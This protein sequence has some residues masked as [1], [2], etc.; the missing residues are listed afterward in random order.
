LCSSTAPTPPALVAHPGR[1][2][3]HRAIGRARRRCRG[4]VAGASSLSVCEEILAKCVCA[5]GNLMS[6]STSTAAVG[7]L[8]QQHAV[9]YSRS[10]AGQ[11]QLCRATGHSARVHSC[12]GKLSSD[13][14]KTSDLRLYYYYFPCPR[15]TSHRLHVV[16]RTHTD[17]LHTADRRSS[18]CAGRTYS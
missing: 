17:T 18:L 3:R 9:A 2:R 7:V 8:K 15:Q 16:H 13:L 14:P 11:Q 6:R 10:A 12:N 1:A 4:A 5:P